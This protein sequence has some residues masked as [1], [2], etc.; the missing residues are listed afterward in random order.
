MRFNQILIVDSIPQGDRNTARELYEDLLLR[1]QIF[2]PAPM[3]SHRRVESNQQLLELIRE[4]TREVTSTGNIPIL[5]VE[6]HGNNDGLTL[7]D[8]SFLSWMEIKEPLIEL[9]IATRMNL[10]VVVSACDGSAIT[11]TLSMVDRAPLYGLIGPIRPVLPNEL[12]RSYLALYETLLRT[13][14]ARDA[15]EA[16]R[17]AT[18][19]TFVFR[20]AKWLF[21]F[22]WDHYQATHETPDARRQRGEKMAANPPAD[23]N[24]R[25]IAPEEFANLLL[26]KNREFFDQYRRKFF[27]CD[28]FEDHEDRFN[29]IYEAP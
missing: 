13:R 28:I 24:G 20:S 15:V 2:A 19:D 22:V 18:P 12:M 29:V 16:M 8:G 4:Q 27:L 3:I 5:H 26:E 1:S 17:E 21:Q 6:C 14:S 23:Y 9:N 25:P 7:S 11:H 10:L